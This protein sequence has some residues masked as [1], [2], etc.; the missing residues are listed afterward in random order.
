MKGLTTK[1][2]SALALSLLF[3]LVAACGGGG[4]GGAPAPQPGLGPQAGGTVSGQILGDPADAGLFGDRS[5]AQAG[6]GGLVG[7]PG[8]EV[9]V[10][11][12]T[13]DDLG[14]DITDDS[15]NFRIDDVPPGNVRVKLRIRT[16]LDFNGDGTPDEVE[17]KI[18]ASVS[19]DQ[20]TQLI[21]Q[22]GLIDLDGDG[23]PDGILLRGT[24]ADNG[25]QREHT[26]G[27][28]PSAGQT[29]PDTNGNGVVDTNDAS[30]AD[31]D[32]D[33]VPDDL[34]SRSEVEVKG[35][36][37]SLDQN[38]ITVGG[39]SFL[40]TSSTIWLDRFGMATSSD[41]FSVGDCVEVK[42]F[43]QGQDL[44]AVRVKLDD[45]CAAQGIQ[46]Q[47]VELKGTIESID[48][49]SITVR[50]V[51]FAITPD[52]QC[53]DETGASVDCASF[54][55]GDFVEVKGIQDGDTLTAV[56]IKLEELHSGGTDGSDDSGGE[57]E[58]E[59]IVDQIGD[60][61][62]TVG[63]QT[64]DMSQ[65]QCFIDE[66]TPVDCST[67]QPGDF[68]EVEGFIDADGNK[69]ATR[70]KLE[71]E[72]EDLVGEDDHPGDEDEDGSGAEDDQD[73]NHGVEDDEENNDNSSGEGDPGSDDD[74]EEDHDNGDSLE[75]DDNGA[76][77]DGSDV[78]DG[79][80]ADGDGAED[81]D[82]DGEDDSDAD[83]HPNGS[84][85][86][87][88]SGG[89]SDED[90]GNGGSDDGSSDDEGDDS[91]DDSNGHGP[92]NDQGDGESGDDNPS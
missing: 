67:I 42:G 50:G 2:L 31:S 56:R 49:Q 68:V 81:S 9:R 26:M 23:Q 77:S 57:F 75:D 35:L 15:G 80:D 48:S 86:G 3:V 88:A 5:T 51:T 28:D 47:E 69:V 58:F 1:N 14:G 66:H 20:I 13:G 55:P 4:G 91:P 54:Q 78:D 70:I 63:G 59:G 43:R 10:E 89:N 24:V 62:I 40:L 11:S 41:A 32:L 45:D 83:D 30:F 65:A 16:Q 39:V 8:I 25:Q 90:N 46:Q 71:N 19:Q 52:T 17:I 44:T 64:W 73:E 76:G 33:G 79:V 84:D 37:E 74:G 61:N 85:D 34:N 21:E 29:I 27:I 7:I 36:I 22:I 53:L 18:L 38:Q 12:E 87:D 60:G 82:S 6:N 92:D 72:F